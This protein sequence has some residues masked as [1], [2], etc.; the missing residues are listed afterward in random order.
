MKYKLTTKELS[1][2]ELINMLNNLEID[3]DEWDFEDKNWDLIGR[4]M[5]LRRETEYNFFTFSLS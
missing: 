3:H 4:D 1:S 2:E 5:W